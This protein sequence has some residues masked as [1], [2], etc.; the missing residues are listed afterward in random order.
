MGKRRGNRNYVFVK[1]EW[2][3]AGNRM[4]IV[5]DPETMTPEI[6][7]GNEITETMSQSYESWLEAETDQMVGVQDQQRTEQMAE[8]A[9][10][11]E[12]TEAGPE[13]NVGERVQYQGREWEID[14][15][16]TDG[17][18]VAHSIEEDGASSETLNIKPE[19]FAQ[20][21]KDV[22]EVVAQ[23][24]KAI[25]GQDVRVINDGKN[26]YNV[27]DGKIDQVYS[28]AKHANTIAEKLSEE[29]PGLKINVH[30]FDKG[31]PFQKNDFTI[32]VDVADQARKVRE[33][34]V[35]SQQ[36]ED[37]NE[38]QPGG[39]LTNTQ[40][41]KAADAG[42][43]ARL[44]SKPDRAIDLGGGDQPPTDVRFKAEEGESKGPPENLV[45]SKGDKVI[46][47]FQD[48]MISV[49]KWQSQVNDRGG[50]ISEFSNPYRQENLSHGMVK[51]AIED[52]NDKFVDPVVG[53][54]SEI[55]QQS[56]MAY[57]EVNEY[58][59]AKHAPERNR[60]L[61]KK[62]GKEVNSGMTTEK[63]EELVKK[64]E[65]GMTE[66]Q[67]DDFWKAVNKATRF[68]LDKQLEYGFIKKKYHTEL[69]EGEDAWKFYVPM[70]GWAQTDRDA[71]Y[72]YMEHD[73]G[74]PVNPF[75]SAKG[76]SSI[77]DDPLQYIVSMAHTAIVM[78]EKNKTKQH[79]AALVRNNKDLTDESG[80]K[81]HSFK[82]VYYVWD[83]TVDK[84][85]KKNYQEVIERPAQ[86]MFDKGYVEMKF[87]SNHMVRRPTS[88][89]K[90]H[91][92]EVWIGGEKYTMILPADVAA[93][94]NKTPSGWDNV[95]FFTQKY[96]GW[97][98]RWLSSNFTSKNPAFIPINQIRDLQYA[99]LSHAIKGEKG[100]ARKFAK[101]IPQARSAIIRELKGKEDLTNKYD[102]MYQDFKRNG[103]ETGYIHMQN[104]D[105]LARNLQKDLR[106][107]NNINEKDYT[108]FKGFKKAVGAQTLNVFLKGGEMLE[109]WAI[110]SENLSRFAT[111]AVAIEAGKSAKQA[112]QEAKDITVNFNRK[113]RVSSLAGSLYAFF[114]A[115]L[116]GGDNIIKLGTKHT[117]KFIG[118]GA[119]FMAMGF[120]TALFNSLWAGDD[121]DDTMND[122]E[123]LNDYQK[124][125]NLVIPVP[126]NEK[127]VT[128]PLPH[129]FRW[130]NSIGVLAYQSLVSQ[131]KDI[132]KAVK[133][134]FETM[135][136]AISPV[137]PIDF[138]DDEGGMTR[139]PIVFTAFMP[140]YDIAKNQDFAGNRIHREPYTAAQEGR[141]ASSQLG[142]KHV[143]RVLK[144]LTDN[145]FKAG[146]GDPEAGSKFYEDKDG[147]I[148]RVSDFMDRNPSDVEHFIEYYLGGR[149]KFW[150]NVAKTGGAIIE[151]AYETV[152]GDKE[153][154]K[155]LSEVNAN[156]VPVMRRL[157]SQPW[158]NSVYTRYYDIIN[159]VDDYKS[160]V[161]AKAGKS[162]DTDVSDLMDPYHEFVQDELKYLRKDLKY[163]DQDIEDTTNPEQIQK[164]KDQQELLIRNFIEQ[165]AK[166]KR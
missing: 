83:G 33:V 39:V 113:G 10:M 85:G 93:G 120:L 53:V 110:R 12:V 164:L 158:Q 112:A 74:K 163:Y 127:F 104:V 32:T 98:T 71:L 65:A 138:L 111:Y 20:I 106:R 26:D 59:L 16:E 23:E 156:N 160:Y 130:F 142:Q 166:Y 4:M 79:A 91:E 133:D 56:G 68:T 141:I 21:L 57:K 1:K 8:T 70:R 62:T 147:N 88:Q 27:V 73:V 148:R 128:I 92:V 153:F 13:F 94:L 11:E 36:T 108:S 24:A 28:T 155:M 46:R 161:Q 52:F 72:E 150:N 101:S 61:Q 124:Y 125:N 149:G 49:K 165:V 40:K 99:F 105:R 145:L 50:K 66:K 109:H 30:E 89:A 75:R 129:G 151:G 9:V 44:T 103:G 43:T 96:V 31:D 144:F 84:D 159:E 146:G 117:G 100:D 58:M 123:E 38:Q 51:V 121:D 118:V 126:G 136:A 140:F 78:G 114:N 154:N 45:Q 107:L 87:N 35:P 82:K 131:E 135:G 14:G 2:D 15:V 122:Y 3:E 97:M 41:E 95:A 47:T 80:K 90:E 42:Y 25:D 48:K 116:Q 77:S 60:E 86:E 162:D 22:P 6:L 63:A 17:S 119:G 37:T 157:Y 64:Y 34:S 132:G 69:T 18:L 115:S 67:I 29:Y 134:G 5:V 55:Q 19:E 7:S 152:S 81:L 137:N 139:R 143:N 102:K 76:R 54:I